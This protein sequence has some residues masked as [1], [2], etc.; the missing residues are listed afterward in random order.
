MLRLTQAIVCWLLL[1]S[2]SACDSPE[3]HDFISQG[4]EKQIQSEEFVIFQKGNEYVLQ[5]VHPFP[6]AESPEFYHLV[7]RDEE[8]RALNGVTHQ[9]PYPLDEFAISSTTH[10]GYLEALGMDHRIV[11]ASSPELFYSSAF[12]ARFERGE[13]YNIGAAKFDEELLIK[14]ETDVLFAFALSPSDLNE[15]N[16]LRLS[17]IKVV[18]VSEFLESDP[19]KK[20]NWLAFFACFFGE[21]KLKKSEVLLTSIEAQYGAIKKAVAKVN[22]KPTVMM[23]YPWKGTW[24]VSG[25]NSY[26]AKFYA[27]AGANYLWSYFDQ[28]GSVPLD[29]EVVLKNAAKADFWLNPGAKQSMSELLKSNPNFKS[30]LAVKN[31][32]VYSNYGRSNTSGANDAWEKGVVRPDLILQDLATIFHPEVMGESDYYFYKHLDK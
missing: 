24:Y 19:L 28:S 29:I 15:L 11:G 20:A 4:F 21:S 31:G 1:I 8:V 12:N 9:I 23:G 27:D 2:I 16:D 7:P 25:G 17:G 14:L 13:I 26:Q 5:V 30:F 18:L 6:K 32:N 22:P 10:L 3:P